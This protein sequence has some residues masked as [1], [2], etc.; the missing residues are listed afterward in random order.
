[1][2]SSN[3]ET[4]DLVLVDPEPAE[5]VPAPLILLEPVEGESGMCD[6]DGW[7]N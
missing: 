4:E 5:P 2:Q 1:M 3:T 7:C 6:A